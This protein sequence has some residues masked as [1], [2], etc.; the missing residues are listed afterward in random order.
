LGGSVVVVVVVLE[1]V[2]D[3]RGEQGKGKRERF[4]RRRQYNPSSIPI[5]P[6]RP[7]FRSPSQKQ[8]VGPD[9]KR[10]PA[11]PSSATKVTPR[12]HHPPYP[13]TVVHRQPGHSRHLN[14][15]KNAGLCRGGSFCA[16]AVS[17][18]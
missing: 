4:W 7:K 12:L 16:G 5:Y 8:R 18:P 6:S 9:P 10:H 3:T 14:L 17:V 11:L 13:P 1:V 2:Y 15:S